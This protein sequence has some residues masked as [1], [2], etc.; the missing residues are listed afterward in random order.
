MA[1]YTPSISKLPARILGENVELR[2][3]DPALWP[4]IEKLNTDQRAELCE[5]L[6][7]PQNAET[8]FSDR[9]N[10]IRW[11]EDS[12]QAEFDIFQR[13]YWIYSPEKN[14][15]VGTITAR[16]PEDGDVL[17]LGCIVFPE[18]R[19][20][21]FA[22]AAASA[23]ADRAFKNGG[24]T[25]ACAET[26]PDNKFSARCLIKAGFREVAGGVCTTSAA[27][28]GKPMRRFI[29]TP[30]ALPTEWPLAGYMQ[31]R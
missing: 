22:S 16:I 6:K 13:G 8:I 18:Y 28:K 24:V 23:L 12:I 15:M 1:G 21:G 14:R 4:Y 5:W 31:P 11:I 30:G 29:K 19:G 25:Y 2:A 20:S 27:F 3:N 9:A 26:T 17:V 10:Y 7:Q